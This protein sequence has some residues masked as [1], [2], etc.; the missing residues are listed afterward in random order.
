MDLLDPVKLFEESW[1]WV[2]GAT[3]GLFLFVSGMTHSLSTPEV[4]ELY[5]TVITTVVVFSVV[6]A[7]LVLILITPFLRL[8]RLFIWSQSQSESYGF[9]TEMQL[10][11]S[12]ASV[13]I[14][15]VVTFMRYVYFAPLERVFFAVLR[16]VDSKQADSLESRS[17]SVP[18]NYMQ[19]ELLRQIRLIGKYLVLG[20]VLFVFMSLP[21]VG[22]L[23]LPAKAIWVLQKK[24][25]IQRAVVMSLV[26]LL[27]GCEIYCAMLLE[28]YLGVMLIA[29]EL[30]APIFLRIGLE[31]REEKALVSAMEPI[32]CGFALPVVGIMISVPVFGPIVWLA[33]QASAALL[34]RPMINEANRI[35]GEAF[36]K[37]NN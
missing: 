24:I 20:A 1:K 30:A 27:P 22:H 5:K 18:E 14:F 37:R 16:A 3:Q 36:V 25:G 34:A 29:R 19:Q 4:L 7:I 12:A 8:Y 9:D 26:S 21:I 23:A 11:L 28:G 33:A 2:K 17:V 32:F 13:F 35:F 10:L 6:V 15:I 31:Y